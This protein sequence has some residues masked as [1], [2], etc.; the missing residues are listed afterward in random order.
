M[1]G[2]AGHVRVCRRLVGGAP[3]GRGGPRRVADHRRLAAEDNA[4]SPRGP[5]PADRPGGVPVG[6]GAG[7]WGSFA[8]GGSTRR[9]RPGGHIRGEARVGGR[10]AALAAGRGGD[11][12]GTSAGVALPRY[13]ILLRDVEGAS[14]CTS[15]PRWASSLCRSFIGGRGRPIAPP[16]VVVDIDIDVDIEIDIDMLTH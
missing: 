8:G 10:E 14:P 13:V 9:G 6:R 3:I 7:P 1:G 5:S 15:L 16:R 12:A 4:A 2:R 11:R